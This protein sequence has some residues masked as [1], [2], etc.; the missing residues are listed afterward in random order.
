MDKISQRSTSGV[1][2][3]VQR[4]LLTFVGTPL[5][6]VLL[7]VGA[8]ITLNSVL[9]LVEVVIEAGG[10]A[11]Q[12][13]INSRKSAYPW[14]TSRQNS[15]EAESG[16]TRDNI[17]GVCVKE[18]GYG[19][20]DVVYT[21]VNGSDPRL[22]ADIAKYKLEVYGSDDSEGVAA[23]N[24]T[25][26]A[27]MEGNNTDTSSQQDGANRWRDNSELKYSLRSIQ[28][29]APW[30]RHVYIVT[31]GQIP[32]WLDLSH[33]RISIVTHEDIFLNRS[34]LPTFS[35]PAIETNLH[36][37]PGLS[38]RFLYLND[39]VMFGREVYPEDFYSPAGVYNVYLS[40]AVPNCADGC[41]DS[42]I[43]DGFCDA[44]CN[45]SSCDWDGGDC[46][47]AT[48]ARGGY[49]Q[50]GYSRSYFS[51]DVCNTGCP[52]TYLGDRFCDRACKVAECGYDAGDCGEEML[53]ENKVHAID[54]MLD[55][56]IVG[57][58]NASECEVNA[59]N[60]TIPPSTSAFYFNLSSILSNSS[61]EVASAEVEEEESERRAM[62]R[63]AVYSEKLRI[64]SFTLKNHVE[65]GSMHVAFSLTVNGTSSSLL[66]FRA[67]Q[68]VPPRNSTSSTSTSNGKVED[69]GKSGNGTDANR[70]GGKRRTI[71]SSPSL[72]QVQTSSKVVTIDRSGLSNAVSSTYWKEEGWEEM[73]LS[74]LS[75][76]SG[77]A[78]PPRLKMK[79]EAE[80][81]KEV[82]RGTGV[83][84]EE[85]CYTRVWTRAIA[86]MEK[87]YKR[88]MSGGVSEEGGSGEGGGVGRR[89]RSEEEKE[90]V[91]FISALRELFLEW[92][93][94]VST[95]IQLDLPLEQEEWTEEE[96]ERIEA[97]MREERG[98]GGG[99]AVMNGDI[100]GGTAASS[101]AL[102][103]PLPA[104]SSPSP[105]PPLLHA[106]KLKDIFGDSL[107]YVNRLFTRAFGSAS[108][109]VPAH[110]PHMMDVQLLDSMQ[111]RWRKQFDATSSHRFRHPADMQYSFSFFYYMMS[112]KRNT[113]LEEF[114]HTVLDADE[115]GRLDENELRTLASFVS[116]P[117]KKEDVKQMR[118]R[119]V[120]AGMVA[121]GI[122]VES[123]DEKKKEASPS[124]SNST[125]PSVLPNST[126]P[127]SNLSTPLPSNS[128]ST[129]P[130]SLSRFLLSFSSPTSTS[131]R[132][133]S[134]GGEEEEEEGED[135]REQQYLTV[136]A[137]R[138]DEQTSKPIM[139]ML[140]GLK[141]FEHKIMTLDEVAFVMVGNN[142]KVID[143]FDNIRRKRNKF[144]CLNDDMDKD[145]PNPVIVK[146]LHDLYTSLYSKPSPFELPP[147]E[148]N[149]Y[150]HRDE[151]R[152]ELRRQRLTLY[153][154]FAAS[155]F[156]VALL[157]Y[158]RLS[159]SPAFAKG[160]RMS[161][162]LCC[163]KR[164]RRRALL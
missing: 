96:R 29:F 127:L 56:D 146:A 139:A 122:E 44:R 121:A 144:V 159:S 162:L 93:S 107:R 25:A 4:S 64:L 152:E 119:L 115:N 83:E 66:T 104:S 77:R 52:N 151:Y 164:G 130:S 37:I 31:N 76:C 99:G 100:Q 160:G 155:G 74:L 6:K 47:N 53:I 22:I 125:S 135:E 92:K 131:A 136:D 2:K 156:A 70:K 148:T 54:V 75:S 39:D 33:P 5:G 27:T 60:F 30:L 16:C 101:A 34:H 113:T 149:T 11:R 108:R 86:A 35:S 10:T 12:E 7:L 41:V 14:Q 109:R 145:K 3:A 50:G 154:L 42:W 157:I 140:D 120:K 102:S 88:V 97:N 78:L 161:S 123:E 134:G 45:T 150:L 20:I 67:S 105:P 28:Q 65:M 116:Y 90:V 79:V 59:G 91:F 51:G 24:V 55:R 103:P 36:R 23:L 84:D 153:L 85:E 21:W 26:N 95:S 112:E 98:G 137:I 43:G 19:P 142:P 13:G 163:R 32:N 128:T 72:T 158:L 62:V 89:A 126:S 68:G 106:R 111:K 63:T 114:F 69:S 38:K 18:L 71:L 133:G 118:K 46:I 73:L 82:E 49:M 48:T 1:R 138:G 15:D 87:E 132:D 57:C 61:L 9:N 117:V 143:Q 124:L 40:W 129:P 81:G 94:T 141:Q 17:G 58:T 80:M 8:I 110:M 147:G